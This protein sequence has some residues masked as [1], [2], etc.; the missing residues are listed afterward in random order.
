M[1]AVETVEQMHNRFQKERAIE[2][3]Q[4]K[5]KILFSLRGDRKYYIAFQCA[6]FEKNI[7]EYG[8]DSYANKQSVKDKG[9]LFDEHRISLGHPYGHHL[10]T[11]DSKQEMIGF[12]IGYN[13][14]ISD[15]NS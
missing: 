3:N 12:V 2:F 11:F 7:I 6:L 15:I 4:A 14:A 1:E 10:K 13:E 8:Y 5:E 9:L